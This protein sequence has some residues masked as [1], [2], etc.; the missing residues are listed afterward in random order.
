MERETIEK[1][2]KSS[3]NNQINQIYIY[4]TKLYSKKK[5][6]SPDFVIIDKINSLSFINLDSTHI[7]IGAFEKL[8]LA[9]TQ[10]LVNLNK[11]L[12]L[13]TKP[14]KIQIFTSN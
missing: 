11:L 3:S 1:I 9:R 12:H 6:N 8:K 14:K 4:T 10:A 13:K 2:K 7:L 5:A